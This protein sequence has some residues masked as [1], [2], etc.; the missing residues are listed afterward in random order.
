MISLRKFNHD[1]AESVRRNLYPDM[2]LQ[3]VLELIDEWNTCVYHERYF[4]AFAIC[5]DD[6]LVGYVSLFE[7]SDS[8]VSFGAE[9]FTDELRKGYAFEG[10]VRPL[11][12]SSRRSFFA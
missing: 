12:K 10:I 6:R 3:A 8:I 4:E 5:S 1:D 11:T 7:H 2:T 9:V